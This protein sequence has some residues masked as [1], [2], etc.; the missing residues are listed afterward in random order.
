MTPAVCQPEGGASPGRLRDYPDEAAERLFD[1]DRAKHADVREQLTAQL[2]QERATTARLTEALARLQ[3]DLATLRNDASARG[4]D[5]DAARARVE[6]LERQRAEIERS[7]NQ[8]EALAERAIRDR[9][10]LANELRAARQAASIAPAEAPARREQMRK[11]DGSAPNAASPGPRVASRP[12]QAPSPTDQPVRLASRQTFHE[13]ITIRIDGGSALLVDLSKT[14]AQV[15]SPTRL[16][17]NQ[18]V[19]VLLPFEGRFVPRR[20]RVVWARLEPISPGGSVRCR[21]GLHFASMNEDAVE[22]ILAR[23][24]PRGPAC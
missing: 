20:G 5:F 7:R 11:A 9:R 12:H 15:L 8:A 3:E 19:K 22:A 24:A 14:G 13:A 2:E 1:F 6:M 16:R 10:A 4:V 23:Y 17:P 18:T 21:A